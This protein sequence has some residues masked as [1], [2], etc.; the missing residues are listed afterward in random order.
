[1]ERDNMV[2]ESYI[3]LQWKRTVNYVDMTSKISNIIIL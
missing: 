3:M 1:M 2:T